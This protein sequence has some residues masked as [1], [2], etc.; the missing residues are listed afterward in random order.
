LRSVSRQAAKPQ[1]RNFFELYTCLQI[2]LSNPYGVMA[3]LAA[4]RET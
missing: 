2:H 4:W 3:F 1:R